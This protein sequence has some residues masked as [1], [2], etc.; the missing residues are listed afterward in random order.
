MES[1]GR[2]LDLRVLFPWGGSP[3]AVPLMSALSGRDRSRYVG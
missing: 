1:P 3:I 2:P